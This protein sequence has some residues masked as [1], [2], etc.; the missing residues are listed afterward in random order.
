MATDLRSLKVNRVIAHEIPRR[1]GKGG[2][3]PILSDLESP[4]TPSLR[5]YFS[6]KVRDT[7]S[8][9]GYEVVLDPASTSPVPGFVAQTFSDSEAFVGLSQEIA[10][11]LFE[12]QTPINPEG[13]L[14]VLD[15]ATD[16]VSALS[17]LKLEKETGVRAQQS[18]KGGKTFFDVQQLNDLLLTQ[19]TRVFKIGVFLDQ[20]DG[21]S[22]RAADNQQ[23]F[24]PRTGI[25][26]FFLKKFLGC[27]LANEPRVVTKT[28]FDATE[29][30][31][32]THISDPVLK[33]KYHVA[34][35][36]EMQSNKTAIS[37]ATFARQHLELDDRQAFIT[38]LEVAMAPVTEFLKDLE[39]V[40]R[41]SKKTQLQ[42]E[43]GINVI[44][45]PDIFDKYVEIEKI[46]GGRTRVKIEDLLI[47]IRGRGR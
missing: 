35:L 15:C 17:V 27:K 23:G 43:S 21:I 45:D 12:C 47:G 14:F 11:H 24:N 39:L 9:S 42:F 46:S 7:L 40:E 31:I 19:K 6:E 33:A 16:G 25:A 4:T 30:F 32:N 10:K 1:T 34:L 26:G 18:L 29:R 20:K 28:F 36:A 37:P 38:S 22:V 8:G 5:N 3:Q 13:L 44:G 2:R 41:L